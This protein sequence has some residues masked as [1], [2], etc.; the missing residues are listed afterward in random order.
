MHFYSIE[1]VRGQA[2][3]VAGR[4][5]E[6][7][8]A[9][10]VEVG[11]RGDAGQAGQRDAVQVAAATRRP[12]SSECS[13]LRVSRWP[14]QQPGGLVPPEASGIKGAMRKVQTRKVLLLESPKR[15]LN[16]IPILTLPNLT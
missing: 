15:P 16:F 2:S 3:A 12:C 13:T 5:P 6:A 8:A 7:E 10:L 4:V 1:N 14:V 9:G 11:D